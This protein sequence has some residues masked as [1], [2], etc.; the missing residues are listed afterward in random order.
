MWG[1][2]EG[3][4]VG[5]T[6][7]GWRTRAVARRRCHGG[8]RSPTRKPPTAAAINASFGIEGGIPDVASGSAVAVVGRAERSLTASQGVRNGLGPA[9]ALPQV[10]TTQLGFTCHHDER[11][12]RTI[13][14]P[15]G[16][17]L[18]AYHSGNPSS[19]DLT[20]RVIVA[21]AR[22]WSVARRRKTNVPACPMQP[23]GLLHSLTIDHLARRRS[24]R[25]S[26]TGFPAQSRNR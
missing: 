22:P 24:N 12:P 7:R 4:L 14:R 18:E 21:G 26:A 3:P 17:A 9:L 20:R 15:V 10:S 13:Q 2:G 11:R 23:S 25:S 19:A 8:R 6:R 5:I 16:N 1:M